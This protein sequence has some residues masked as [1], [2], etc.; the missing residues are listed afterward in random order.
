MTK[1]HSSE[2]SMRCWQNQFCC[3]YR[4]GKGKER[5]RSGKEMK[6]AMLQRRVCSASN[7]DIVVQV[8]LCQWR[9]HRPA[10]S[11]GP[12]SFSSRGPTNCTRITFYPNTVWINFKV[13][14]KGKIVPFIYFPL[15]SVIKQLFSSKTNIYQICAS[16]L[17]QNTIVCIVVVLWIVSLATEIIWPSLIENISDSCAMGPLASTAATD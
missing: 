4:N 8:L 1:N 17:K 13:K 2:Y 16:E 11:R 12:T 10:S 5:I 15:I 14:L 9:L 3:V 6:V 7:S